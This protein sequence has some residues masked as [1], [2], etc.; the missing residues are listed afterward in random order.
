[1]GNRLSRLD[2]VRAALRLVDEGGVNG[3]SMRGVA[4]LLGVYPTAV[5]W[6]AG[7]KAQLLG[8]VCE[9]V[10][11]EV[12]LSVSEHEEPGPVLKKYA[13]EVRSTLMKH[14]RIVPFMASQLQVVSVPIALTEA[15][16][17]CLVR[18]GHKGESLRDAYNLYIATT[19]GWIFMEF[20]AEPSDADAGWAEEFEQRLLDVDPATAPVL[21]ANLKFLTNDA[22]TLRW[23]TGV[24]RPMLAG[25]SY[26]IDTMITGLTAH[27]PS[28]CR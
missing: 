3:F 13:H 17:S 19:F 8:S 2:V 20:T 1:M 4:D 23:E 15:V 7:A 21:H 24:S 5:Y 26:A 12:D 18:I 11:A 22:F 16:L 27:A 14:P 28:D 25:F 10:I 9:Y 6:H